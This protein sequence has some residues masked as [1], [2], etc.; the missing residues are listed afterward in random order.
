MFF[1]GI[2]CDGTSLFAHLFHDGLLGRL[3]CYPAKFSWRFFKLDLI[4]Q[5]IGRTDSQGVLETDFQAAVKDLVHDFTDSIDM[6]ITCFFIKLNGCAVCL[7]VATT[8]SRAKGFCHCFDNIFF[9]NT[10]VLF[11]NTEGL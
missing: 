1:V 9:F 8:I 3:S 5:L 2:V 10:F 7:T 4:S 11:Q 6:E